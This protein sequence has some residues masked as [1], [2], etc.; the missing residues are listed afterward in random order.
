MPSHER[1]TRHT[2][3]NLGRRWPGFKPGSHVYQKDSYRLRQ[4][5]KTKQNSFQLG[6]LT[7]GR[8]VA[9]APPATLPHAAPPT[10]AASRTTTWADA[11]AARST[12]TTCHFALLT[13][14]AGATGADPAPNAIKSRC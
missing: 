1:I 5:N 3:I 10:T 8:S 12:Q 11:S 7:P 4:S 13:P 14:T 6:I 9:S 2:N